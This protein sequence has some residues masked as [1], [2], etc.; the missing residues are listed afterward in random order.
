MPIKISNMEIVDYTDIHIYYAFN[1]IDINKPETYLDLQRLEVGT[2]LSKYFSYYI[3][4]YDSLAADFTI[5]NPRACSVPTSLKGRDN[6][7][8]SEYKYSEYFK[9]FKKIH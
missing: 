1:A 3:F 8:W 7:I 9:D 6:F 5:K 2:I 4:N